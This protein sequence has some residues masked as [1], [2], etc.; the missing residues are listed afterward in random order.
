MDLNI[1]IDSVL[2]VQLGH[3][4]KKN[5]LVSTKYCET[6]RHHLP[7]LTNCYICNVFE[8]HTFCHM[9]DNILKQ[10]GAELEKPQ[11]QLDLTAEAELVLTVECPNILIFREGGSYQ[12]SSHF[13][14]F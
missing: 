4:H 13:R 8:I 7:W 6:P 1:N 11:D 12:F 3:I 2:I 9:A 5:V 14:Q 10:A